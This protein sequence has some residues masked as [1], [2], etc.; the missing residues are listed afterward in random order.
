MDYVLHET[1][2]VMKMFSFKESRA[3]DHKTFEYTFCTHVP[4]SSNQNMVLIFNTVF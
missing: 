1:A 3:H 2:C 4:K